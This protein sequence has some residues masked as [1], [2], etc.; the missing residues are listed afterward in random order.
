MYGYRYNN[1]IVTMESGYRYRDVE[2]VEEEAEIVRRIFDEA[3]LGLP[4]AQIARSLNNDHIAPPKSNYTRKHNDLPE[5][6]RLKS[7]INEGWT[8]RQISQILKKERYV[9]DVRIQKTYTVDYLTHKA[10]KNNGEIEQYIVHN[11][12]QAIVSREVYEEAQKIIAI[13]SNRYGDR[14]RNRKMRAFSGRL[15][16]GECGRYYNV[17]NTDKN[18]IWYCPSSNLNNGRTVCHSQ[19][20]YEEWIVKMFR[21]AFTQQYNL[22]VAKLLARMESVQNMDYMERDRIIQKR[23]I[24][25][26]RLTNKNTRKRLSKLE[27]EKKYMDSNATEEEIS[28]ICS[29]IER[30]NKKLEEGKA[31]EQRQI[32]SLNSLEKYW[33]QLEADY[34]QREKAIEWLKSLPQG[35]EGRNKLLDGLTDEYAKAF[36]LS[37]TI[38]SPDKY[39]IH[40]FDNSR[41]VVE[42]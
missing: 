27:N 2:I 39:T 14:W 7:H 3:I 10:R 36:A 38:H 30:E 11:H 40:W 25:A 32:E 35:E 17:R 18:P 4:Y 19:K 21:K 6:G 20:V 26:I 37:I 16:C 41:T 23:L 5:N 31:E 8:P 29:K 24:A 33:K 34:D 1:Q 28:D 15:I 22:S 42:M 13:N 12:H 9:G